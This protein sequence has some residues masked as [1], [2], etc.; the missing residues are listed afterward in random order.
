MRTVEIEIETTAT[1]STAAKIEIE[2]GAGEMKGTE[3]EDVAIVKSPLTGAATAETRA[4]GARPAEG[5]G[6]RS[7][8]TEAPPAAAAGA[9][10]T[11]SARRTRGRGPTGLAAAAGLHRRSGRGAS[12]V[13]ANPQDGCPHVSLVGF[14]CC[15]VRFQIRKLALVVC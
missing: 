9:A 10:G 4:R 2:T 7:L 11:G 14:F 12:A 15:E 8:E 3:R 1:E 5:A 6:R 13:E